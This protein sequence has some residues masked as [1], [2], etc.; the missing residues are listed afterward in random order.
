MPTVA[1]NL[2]P[3][4]TP[5][6]TRK[7]VPSRPGGRTRPVPNVT[8]PVVKPARESA[9]ARQARVIAERQ[10]KKLAAVERKNELAKARVDGIQTRRMY[11]ETARTDFRKAKIDNK[12]ALK[13]E[14]AALKRTS[15]G[16]L[17]DIFTTPAG[18]DGGDY[19]VYSGGAESGAGRDDVN[20]PEN[21]RPD[22]P[23]LGPKTKLW[24]GVAGVGGVLAF[25]GWR[26][27]TSPIRWGKR[28][29]EAGGGIAGAV[30]NFHSSMKG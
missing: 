17:A 23:A 28:V 19:P 25:F 5:V 22:K 6:L 20:V 21:G 14:R 13:A 2:T 27:V 12:A 9:A 24:L 29:I 10:A 1:Q 11:A 8:A 30:S 4:V 7:P 26:Y 3:Y 18:G 15:G 16:T